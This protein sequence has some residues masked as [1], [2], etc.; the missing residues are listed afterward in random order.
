LIAAL[1]F[2]SGIAYAQGKTNIVIIRHAGEN[3]RLSCA[4][5]AGDSLA[6]APEA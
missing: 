3:H 5:A 4:D 2:G 1:I 6:T